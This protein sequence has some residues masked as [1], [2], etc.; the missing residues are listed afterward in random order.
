MKYS[1][2][3]RAQ[4]LEKVEHYYLLKKAEDSKEFEEGD[5]ISYSGRVYD[6][7]EMVNLV[8]SSL[9][10]WLTSGKYCNEFEKKFVKWNDSK[11][12]LFVNSG[13]SANLLA[14]MALTSPL[15]NKSY[16]EKQ[17][18]ERGDEVITVSAGFPTTISPIVNFGAIPV[19]VDVKLS[20]FNIDTSQLEKALSPKTR[21]VFLAHTL[22]NTFDMESVNEFCND[23][24]LWLISD[25]CDALGS[26][27]NNKPLS[28]YADISTHS[29]YPAHIMTT[30]Q[31]GMVTT[32]Q[33]TLNKIMKSIRDWGRDCTC[34][35]GED[36][37]CGKRFEGQYGDMPEGF[38]HKYIYSHL[39][40][41]LQATEMQASIGLAQLDKL[42]GFIKQR[43]NNFKRLYEGLK[44]LKDYIILP[45]ATINSNPAWFGFYFTIIDSDR[46]NRNEL[47]QFLENSGIQSRMLFSGNI[48]KQPCFSQL[49]EYKDYRKIGDLPNTN[50][51]MEDS[52]WVGVFPGMTTE[53]LD[54]M[55]KKIKEYFVKN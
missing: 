30:G 37:K 10:F 26:T 20:T 21:A 7:R 49:T 32:E 9:D 19:F 11:Y 38:D 27:Y 47:A 31:G 22:G 25:E 52:L 42:D 28:Y 8:S 29:F 55:I 54:Y 24:N 3:V 23:N 12:A 1:E 35:T 17:R 16:P 34:N 33:P 44:D 5:R 15:I 45:R 53:K 18:I 51:I 46:Y 50:K 14:F 13:S 6:E 4:I 36:N 48:I 43:R 40:Y 2:L 39:G 41:N